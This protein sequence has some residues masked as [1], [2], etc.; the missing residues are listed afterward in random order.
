MKREKKKGRKEDDKENKEMIR[1]YLSLFRLNKHCFSC[2][3]QLRLFFRLN[4]PLWIGWG[5]SLEISLG[6]R[7]NN[8]ST[9]STIWRCWRCKRVIYFMIT[10]FIIWERF[11]VFFLTTLNWLKAIQ[12]QISPLPRGVMDIGGG[13]RHGDPSSNL[14]WGGLRFT[15]GE[16]MNLTILYPDRGK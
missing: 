1:V 9:V 4:Q 11:R 7:T 3:N 10:F 6:D 5:A 12:S 8:K 16:G 2:L 14:E 15:F 13:N